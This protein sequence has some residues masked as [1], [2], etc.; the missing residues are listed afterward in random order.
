MRNFY[1]HQTNIRDYD[2]G[3]G[4]EV[5]DEFGYAFTIPDQLVGSGYC[6]EK[7]GKYVCLSNED[8]QI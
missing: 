7:G 3:K 8:Y 6:I 2:I 4:H 5:L 1:V